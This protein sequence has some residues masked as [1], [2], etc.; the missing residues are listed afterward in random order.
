M[1]WSL[2]IGL[3]AILGS[4]YWLTLVGY[5]LLLSLKGL[6]ASAVPLNSALEQL[7]NP[8]ER[9]FTAAKNHTSEDLAEVLAKREQLKRAKR[10]ST[11]ARRRRLVERLNQVNL[12][13]R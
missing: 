9:Q 5:R 2:L 11:E 12:D 1:S 10:D 4:L 8:I 6:K 7:A 3:A 13:K